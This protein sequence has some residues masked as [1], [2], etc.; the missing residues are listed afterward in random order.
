MAVELGPWAWTLQEK[1][2]GAGAQAPHQK[3]AQTEHWLRPHQ[4]DDGT[5]VEANKAEAA[6][7][8]SC[9]LGMSL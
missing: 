2:P 4:L 1:Y 6:P 3:K 8:E 5:H 7:I 9:T